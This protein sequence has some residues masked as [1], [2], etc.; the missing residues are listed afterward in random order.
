M[1]RDLLRGLLAL[2]N[3]HGFGAAADLKIA[4]KSCDLNCVTH[5]GQLKFGPD[6]CGKIRGR[7]VGKGTSR[8]YLFFFYCTGTVIVCPALIDM[9]EMYCPP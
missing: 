7:A 1:V 4:F 3:S 2:G 9:Y 5:I 8:F 6:A